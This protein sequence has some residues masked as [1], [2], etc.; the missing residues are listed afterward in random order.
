[1]GKTPAQ[2]QREIA[3]LRDELGHRADRTTARVRDDTQTTR[4]TIKRDVRS[5]LS[6]SSVMQRRPLVV[7]AASLGSGLALG[8]LTGNGHQAE[9]DDEEDDDDD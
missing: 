5:R 6:P 3:Q 2:L 9:D 1:M 4:E 7:V 8:W